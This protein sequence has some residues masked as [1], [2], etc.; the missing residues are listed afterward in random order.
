MCT[1]DQDWW[2]THAE[3]WSSS[4]LLSS[5]TLTF[6]VDNRKWILIKMTWRVRWTAFLYKK[7]PAKESSVRTE[8]PASSK[9]TP[10]RLQNGGFSPPSLGRR[11]SA[12]LLALP[13]APAKNQ[14]SSIVTPMNQP[15]SVLF[16]LLLL[17]LFT[18]FPHLRPPHKGHLSFRTQLNHCHV[19]GSS[20]GPSSLVD[21][22]A[23]DLVYQSVFAVNINSHEIS[24]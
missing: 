24:V 19:S 14:G 17:L 13:A 20:S 21:V 15:R 9:S 18:T 22:P 8:Q 10:R 3:L 16:C 2:V 4:R 11:P 7:L 12:R 23:L 5:L 1:I 6:L